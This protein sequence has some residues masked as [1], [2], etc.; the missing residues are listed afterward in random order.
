MSGLARL[1]TPKAKRP[2]RKRSAKSLETST[3]LISV[4]GAPR[5][6]GSMATWDATTGKLIEGKEL[7]VGTIYA[8]GVSADEKFL[9]LG[10]G[11]SLRAE[12]DYNT[13]LI[14]KR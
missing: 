5:L 12:K 3:A 4:G 6:K 9:G 10:T 13:G 7:S 1:T 2:V 11:G 8:L 14:L